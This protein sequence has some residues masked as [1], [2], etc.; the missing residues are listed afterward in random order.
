MVGQMVVGRGGG[1]AEKYP[2]EGAGPLPTEAKGGDGREE[3]HR[4]RQ[5]REK[6][7]QR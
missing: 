5:K 4:E 6:T 1:E 3:G 2:T 7:G